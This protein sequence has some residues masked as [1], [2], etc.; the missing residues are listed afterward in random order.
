MPC[1]IGGTPAGFELPSPRPAEATPARS[2][3][4]A[5]NSPTS[6]ADHLPDEWFGYDA[7]DLV[8][9]NTGDASPGR[10]PRLFAPSRPPTRE[11]DALLGM[12]PPRRPDRRLRWQNAKR[13]ETPSPAPVSTVRREVRRAEPHHGGGRAVLVRRVTGQANVM[14]AHSAEGKAP[15][16]LANLAPKRARPRPHSAAG[17][18]PED[19]TGRG[20]PLGLGRAR[21]VGFDL[22]AAPSADFPQRVEFWDW[23]L[24]KR[25]RTGLRRRRRKPR[26]PGAH[27]RRRRSRGRDP[28]PQRHLRWRRGGLVRLDRD[29]D[30]ALHPAHRPD[31]ILLPQRILGRLELTWITFPIIVLSVSDWRTSR[32]TR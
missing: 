13:R 18:E 10:P 24:R 14:A 2:A 15:F 22:D 26:P 31:R 7:I 17:A 20:G 1:A 28:A 11:R 25:R 27:R 19:P 21:S 29:A 9:L 3:A 16:A 12:G 5:S 32:P 4:A 23:V 8:L 30:R 6:S